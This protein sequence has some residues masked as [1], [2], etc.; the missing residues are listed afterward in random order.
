M[1]YFSPAMAEPTEA[2]SSRLTGNYHGRPQEDL[3]IFRLIQCDSSSDVRSRIG[4][5]SSV[6]ST[7]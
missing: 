5:M 3:T 2:V 1:Q 7:N 6:L 4:L